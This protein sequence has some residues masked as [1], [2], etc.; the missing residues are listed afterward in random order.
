M[1]IRNLTF[2]LSLFTSLFLYAQEETEQERECKRARFLAGE[3]LKVKNYQE[4][5][6]YY[7]I[8]EKWCNGYDKGN[9]DRLLGSLQYTINNET[10]AAKKSK[11]IDTLLAYYDKVETLGFIDK[12]VSLTRGLYELQAAKP[13]NSKIDKLLKEGIDMAG[14]K[15]NGMYVKYYYQNLYLL[16][17]NNTGDAKNSFKK[18]VI[19]EYFTLSKMATDLA[20]P[21]DVKESMVQYFNNVVNTCADILP[22][23]KGFLANLPQEVEA[24]KTTVNNFIT[25]LESKNC[26][27][28]KEYEILIDTLIKIDPSVGAVIAKAKLLRAKKK[29]S[30]ALSVYKEAKAMSTENAQ[31]EELEYEI[32][33]I[34]YDNLDQYKAAYSTA[35]G[36][37]GSKRNDALRIAAGCVM[38]LA[39]SCGTSTFER[40]CNYY[41]AA[42]LAEKANDN[43]T[44]SKAKANFPTSEDI[45]NE[46]KSKGQSVSLSCWGVNVTIK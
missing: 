15:V 8:G 7:I 9:Y 27:D 18:R 45:F 24:K 4:A 22:D 42:E 36:I 1:N 33:V 31:K 3:A 12:S 29:Y 37:S 19:S 44:A 43:N 25:L 41:Y 46:G 32:L 10:D 38:K 11:Y 23:L 16:Y 13:N 17:A 40:K 2:G 6:T 20:F 28:A 14:D 39:N 5:T 21:E 35:M 34:Q 30:E 26:T